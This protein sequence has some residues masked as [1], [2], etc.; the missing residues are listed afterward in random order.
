MGIGIVIHALAALMVGEALVGQQTL[1]RQ[2]L[3]PLLRALIY[4]Q[5]QGLVLSIGLPPSDLKL[6]TGALVLGVLALRSPSEG[7]RLL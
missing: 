3:A 6:F 1:C 2:L 4:Q 5:I 7:R